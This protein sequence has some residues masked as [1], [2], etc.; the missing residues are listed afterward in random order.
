M[1]IG[2]YQTGLLVIQDTEFSLPNS[3]QL[4]CDRKFDRCAIVVMESR[5]VGTAEEL[6]R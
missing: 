2:H 4:T 6:S 5:G 3:C 1:T